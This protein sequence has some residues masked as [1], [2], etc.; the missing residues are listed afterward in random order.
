MASLTGFVN[1]LFL[2]QLYIVLLAV[3]ELTVSLHE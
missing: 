2:R 1:V 3:L